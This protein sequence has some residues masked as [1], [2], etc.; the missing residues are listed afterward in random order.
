M[1]RRRE[2]HKRPENHHKILCNYGFQTQLLQTI[3]ELSELID[4][5]TNYQISVNQQLDERTI[6]TKA[7]DVKFE[8]A[9]VENMLEQMKII[10]GDTTEERETKMIRQLRRMEL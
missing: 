4:A 1:N 8:I 7:K 10:F 5:L 9:D 6:N 3:Q 2:E